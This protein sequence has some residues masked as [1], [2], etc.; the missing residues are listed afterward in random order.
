[1][2]VFDKVLSSESFADVTLGRCQFS[3]LLM[4]IVEKTG[5]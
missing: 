4:T 5:S 3:S 1:M 2:A